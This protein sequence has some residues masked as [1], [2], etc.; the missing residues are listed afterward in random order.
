MPHRGGMGDYTCLQELE[1]FNPE[2]RKS[3]EDRANKGAAR[4]LGIRGDFADL[5]W[6]NWMMIEGQRGMIPQ[7]YT[8]LMLDTTA[9][10]I[11][12]EA[13]LSRD[14]PRLLSGFVG[15]R[16]AI[17]RMVVDI[18]GQ[19]APRD[20]VFVDDYTLR[21]LAYIQ[22]GYSANASQLL[23]VM[24]EVV[25][26]LYKPGG[27]FYTLTDIH[28]VLTRQGGYT[29][30]SWGATV[31]DQTFVALYTFSVLQGTTSPM[32]FDNWSSGFIRAIEGWQASGYMGSLADWLLDNW[33]L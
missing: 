22:L 23:E 32:M 10:P 2:F 33:E 15:T 14:D 21:S 5:T 7:C 3:R 13:K 30:T 25:E 24:E 12:S 6:E 17:N 29:Y 1:E 11:N 8:C 9:Y 20:W 31:E 26:N 18:T 27:G 19:P 4:D 16:Q 28:S